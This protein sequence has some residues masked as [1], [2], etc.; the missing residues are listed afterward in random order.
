M[1]A[2][3]VWFNRQHGNMPVRVNRFFFL[4][5]LS[6]GRPA[7]ASGSPQG[8]IMTRSLRNAYALRDAFFP[9]LN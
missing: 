1:F 8:F 2:F 4:R 3:Q 5:M 9:E 6:S 7:R